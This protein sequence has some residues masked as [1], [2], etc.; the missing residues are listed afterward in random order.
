VLLVYA[1][2]RQINARK[3]MHLKSEEDIGT[4]SIRDEGF[5]DLEFKNPVQ[6]L[7]GQAPDLDSKYEVDV[8]LETRLC[9]AVTTFIRQLGGSARHVAAYETLY[10][11][12]FH[13]ELAGNTKFLPLLLLFVPTS[14]HRILLAVVDGVGG[15]VR[16]VGTRARPTKL[17]R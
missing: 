6:L 1:K 4:E 9:V 2:T 11:D 10:S 8:D 16:S 7:A 14:T 13:Y 12:P 3:K 17:L 15:P 5:A